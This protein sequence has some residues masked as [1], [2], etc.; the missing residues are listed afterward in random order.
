MRVNGNPSAAQGHGVSEQRPELEVLEGYRDQDTASPNSLA[1]HDGHG[2][3]EEEKQRRQGERILAGVSPPRP[4]STTNEFACRETPNGGCESGGEIPEEEHPEPHARPDPPQPFV[5]GRQ[6]SSVQHNGA[7]V[8]NG[9]RS[10]S[11]EVH[12]GGGAVDH[13]E[14]STERGLGMTAPGGV[15]GE[16]QLEEAGS[17][18]GSVGADV[19]GVMGL[20][21]EDRVWHE[22]QLD[23]QGSQRLLKGSVM[24]AA[25]RLSVRNVCSVRSSSTSLLATRRCSRVCKELGHNHVPWHVSS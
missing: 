16:D 13:M 19:N 5:S 21:Q 6:Q 3:E 4:L 17:R 14:R 25:L 22:G 23:R 11:A 15:I 20:V 12:V 9:S 7:G 8:P 10:V 24:F 1:P 18:R 2:E